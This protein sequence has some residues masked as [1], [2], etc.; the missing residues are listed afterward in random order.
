MT[1]ILVVDDDEGEKTHCRDVLRGDGFDVL[2]CDSVADGERL[3]A[4][5]DSPIALVV[6]LW[7]LRGVYGGPEFLVRV[8]ENRPAIK[9]I[10]TIKTWNLSEAARAR[11]MGASG[12]V[13]RPVDRNR[14][15][16]AVKRSLEHDPDPE[17]LPELRAR[18]VGKSPK[19]LDALRKLA[20][21]IPNDNHVLLVGEPGT[22]KELF[23]QAVRDLSE[24]RDS[25]LV[26]RNVATIPE[27]VRESVLFGHE[28]GAFTGADRRHEG[29][30][31]QTGDGILF[32]DE[33]GEL[34]GDTQ[35]ALLRVIDRREFNRV[36][37][38]DV[39]QF[40]GRLVLATNRDLIADVGS[41]KFREDLYDRIAKFQIALPPMRERKDDLWLLVDH[42]L[43]EKFQCDRKIHLARETKSLLETYSFPGN[44]RELEGI[45]EWAIIQ[46]G[47][48]EILPQHLPLE[49]MQQRQ[50]STVAETI[51]RL[52]VWPNRLYALFEKDALKEIAQAF[53][54][55]YLP[56]KLDEAK[57]VVTRAAELAGLDPKTFR[58]RWAQA[59]LPRLSADSP[60]RQHQSQPTIS[61][62]SLSAE[63]ADHAW[64][65][66]RQ[67]EELPESHED[68][69][70]P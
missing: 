60:S 66:L 46:A 11:E 32:L 2:V 15:L 21:V 4:S 70:Q 59:G 27:N 31:E 41:H 17:L 33:I 49:R 12:F 45:L 42:F 58:T 54:R 64:E 36:G 47:S 38:A 29:Y 1:K 62:Q 44:V 34:R 16:S 24:R 3:L 37:S 22:G 51:A 18:L 25:P 19:F 57:H 5:T 63:E 14:L 40:N 30:F 69:T 28:K 52:F 67:R 43:Y 68:W 23:A 55:E 56:R 48:G 7:D 61:E 65:M 50:P 39:L 20:R 6:L 8:R 53:D 10:V 13:L 35:A 9:V 26:A